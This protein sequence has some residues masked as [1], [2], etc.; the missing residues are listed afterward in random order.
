MTYRTDE[1][2]KRLDWKSSAELSTSYSRIRRGEETV[3]DVCRL[4][5][6]STKH[7]NADISST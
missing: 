4:V 5:E 7:A 1:N 2:T 6:I 3:V